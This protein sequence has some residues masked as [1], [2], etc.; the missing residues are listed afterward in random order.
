MMVPDRLRL[1]RFPP[2]FAVFERF[3][4]TFAPLAVSR[5]FTTLAILA[6]GFL[7]ATLMLGLSIG[8]LHRPNDSQASGSESRIIETPVQAEARKVKSFHF[9]FGLAC[10]LVVLLVNSVSLTYFV[11]TS[12]WTKEVTA[13]YS[14]DGEYVRRSTALKRRCWPLSLTG[15]LTMVAIVALGAASDPA[16]GRPGTEWWATPHFIGALVGTSYIALAFVLQRNLIL[17][18]Y[19]VIAEVMREVETKQQAAEPKE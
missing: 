7:A 18:N 2:I 13:A 17:Q 9:L 6:V 4:P 5:I 14:L 1:G 3:P 8:E 12:R 11:G 16:T 15:M 19:T 10:S